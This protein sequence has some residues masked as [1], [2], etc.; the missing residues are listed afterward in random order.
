LD[1]SRYQ[2]FSFEQLNSNEEWPIDH[3]FANWLKYFNIH[4]DTIDFAKDIIIDLLPFKHLN[5]IS[6]ALE[7]TCYVSYI[8]NKRIYD[9][10][11]QY[12]LKIYAEI[13]R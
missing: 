4:T 3:C 10:L 9:S 6:I 11:G 1:L 12:G 5:K 7:I 13:S 8:V 2:I